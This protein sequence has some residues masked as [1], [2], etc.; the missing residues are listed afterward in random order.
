MISLITSPAARHRLDAVRDWL[1]GRDPAQ[2]L[3]GVGATSL[4]ARAVVYAH[5]QASFGWQ[6]TT[7][8]GLAFQ[9]ALPS[10]AAGGLVP[11]TPASAEALVGRVVGQLAADSKLGRYEAVANAP[12]FPRALL[13]TLGELAMA[14]V[15]VSAL[16]EELVEL[17]TIVAGYRAE[18]ALSLIHI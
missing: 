12:G 9:L 4:A 1:A 10:L 14:A 5:T 6:M 13:S 3:L 16:P 18:L 15:P 8:D 11:T 7:L 17:R 2:P